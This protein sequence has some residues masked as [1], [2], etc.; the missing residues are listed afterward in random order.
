M[1]LPIAD[2]HSFDSFYTQVTCYRFRTGHGE[3][4]LLLS[5]PG[6]TSFSACSII[7]CTP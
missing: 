1:N 4:S 3:N 2:N 7:Y 6:F 5:Y